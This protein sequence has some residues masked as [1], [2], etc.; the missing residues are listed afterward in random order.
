MHVDAV[1]EMAVLRVPTDPPAR[2]WDRFDPF[3]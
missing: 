2:P 3:I 1:R